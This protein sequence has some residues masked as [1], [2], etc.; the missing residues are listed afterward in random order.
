MSA[1]ETGAVMTVEA[2]V[3]EAV[4]R[5]QVAAEDPA[6]AEIAEELVSLTGDFTD[7]DLEGADRDIP[8]ALA[9]LL[10]VTLGDV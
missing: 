8:V 5:V 9:A 10:G 4:R 6:N 2:V 1:V 3:A 7:A